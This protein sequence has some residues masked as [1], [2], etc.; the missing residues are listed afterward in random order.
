MTPH[1]TSPRRPGRPSPSCSRWG[2]SLLELLATIAIIGVLVALLVPALKAVRGSASTASELVTARQ[3]MTAYAAYAF[4]H[5]S[6]V[7]PG[8][9]SQAPALPAVNDRGET[10]TGE[11]ARRYP[12]RLAPY[13]DFSMTALL[14]DAD[15]IRRLK[16][17]DPALVDYWIS[18]Y[19]SM[20][21]NGVFVGRDTGIDAPY[22]QLF[23]PI[24]ITRISQAKRPAEALATTTRVGVPVAATA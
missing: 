12:W 10:L 15:L 1:R 20:G 11:A 16:D 13:V 22:Q 4:D 9:W 2:F 19:P 7:L 6:R 24:A 3:L 18:L 5:E 23:G 8:Y 21:I 17:A 14:Q